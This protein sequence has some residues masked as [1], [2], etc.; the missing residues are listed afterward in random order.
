MTFYIHS[1]IDQKKV[2]AYAKLIDHFIKYSSTYINYLHGQP[3]E[4]CFLESIS[5]NPEPLIISD[6]NWEQLY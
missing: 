4:R 1:R 5:G 3:F 6:E 2:F